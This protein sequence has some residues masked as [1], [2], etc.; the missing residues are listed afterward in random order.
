MALQLAH[1]HVDAIEAHARAEVPAECCGILA[2][3]ME[4][5][6]AHVR[7]VHPAANVREGDRTNGFL[8]D[9]RTH[10]RLQRDC[11]QRDLEI[12]GFYHSHP[13]GS[14][15]PSGVDVEWAWPGMSYVIISIREGRPGELRSWRFDRDAE[16]FTEERVEI[17]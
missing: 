9:P 17:V 7:E 2:G 15:S 12:V 1:E 16:R 8:L 5:G 4:E 11:R 14:A 3:T 13:A 6:C 10:L